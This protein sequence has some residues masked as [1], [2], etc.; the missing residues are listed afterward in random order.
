VLLDE[1]HR[2]LRSER[3]HPALD[4]VRDA[5]VVA[6]HRLGEPLLEPAIE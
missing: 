2:A 3:V 4:E 5:V 1:A 6:V